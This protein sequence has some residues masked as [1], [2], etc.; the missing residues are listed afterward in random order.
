[1][2]T[3]NMDLSSISSDASHRSTN[4]ILSDISKSHPT[5]AEWFS[6]CTGSTSSKF[7]LSK[8]RRTGVKLQRLRFYR[9][10]TIAKKARP[11]SANSGLAKNSCLIILGSRKM[12]CYLPLFIAG[13]MFDFQ[14]W[15]IAFK[16]GSNFEPQPTI[17]R[18]LA[19]QQFRVQSPGSAGPLGCHWFSSAGSKSPTTMF[20]DIGQLQHLSL[21]I[22]G[23]GAFNYP[24]AMSKPDWTGIPGNVE[25]TEKSGNI[26]IRRL[27]RQTT[28][29]NYCVAVHFFIFG[30]KG[31][32]LKKS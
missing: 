31:Q 32:I 8:T 24:I 2:S 5:S 15:A 12:S 4:L 27:P 19:K 29:T 26:L 3:A 22:A 14:C 18:K 23:Q 20:R 17:D 16:C 9:R 1:M 21:A 13:S 25:T 6:V 7:S 10:A 11:P 30:T 28:S